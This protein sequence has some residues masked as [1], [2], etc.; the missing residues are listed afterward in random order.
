MYP[1]GSVEL[2]ELLYLKPHRATRINP[3]DYSLGLVCVHY[4]W[5]FFVRNDWEGYA[6]RI[7]PS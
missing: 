6:R 1:G 4:L 3:V 2:L 7:V 5:I